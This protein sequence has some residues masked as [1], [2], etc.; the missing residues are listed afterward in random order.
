MHASVRT[1]VSRSTFGPKPQE[2][3]LLSNGVIGSRTRYCLFDPLKFEIGR[4]A[5]SIVGIVIVRVTVVVDITEIVAIVLIDR[6][7]ELTEIHLRQTGFVAVE[8]SFNQLH[9]PVNFL[10]E[11][12]SHT[13]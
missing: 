5:I 4:H 7:V 9:F 8:N 13:I 3:P 2:V 10:A 12:L 11:R 1:A 6:T